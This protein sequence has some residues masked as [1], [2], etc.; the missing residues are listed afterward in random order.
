MEKRKH[1]NVELCAFLLNVARA[2]ELEGWEASS[3]SEALEVTQETQWQDM[4]DG[5]L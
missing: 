2:F 3:Y 1:G 4:A 5:V